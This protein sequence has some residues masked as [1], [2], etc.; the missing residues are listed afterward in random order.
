MSQSHPVLSVRNLSK[1]FKSKNP[2]LAVDD[3][4]F[5]LMQ[6]EILGLLGP[7]GA[8]KTT[9][10]QMLLSTLKP[11]SGSIVYFG[12]DFK[13][14]RSEILN[15]VVFA[16][17]Y[18]SLPYTLTVEQNLNVFGKLYGIGSKE[19][20]TRR[21]E[22]LERFGILSK[23]KMPVSTLSAGQTTRLVLVKAF[24]TKP[25]IALLDEPTASLDPDI[26]KDIISFVLE[27]RDKEGISILFTSHNMS[28]VAEV[29]DRVLFLQNGRII[30]NDEPRNLAKSASKSRI[31]L[32]LDESAD[33]VISVAKSLSIIFSHEHKR[34]TFEIDEQ[35]IAPFLLE[36][37]K[38][39]IIYSGIKI[40]E[41]TLEDY[42]LKMVNENK[43]S[44]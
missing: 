34:F 39:H 20:Q 3:I 38:H 25:K 11:T 10:I 17:T 22:L 23:L 37:A 35:Q 18:I 26:S 9:T 16:S 12:K 2:F 7:N 6:G 29:S 21:N 43:K 32:I 40:F 44:V 36:L 19:L 28:E 27:Q 33:K 30:A 41:P 13:K 5:D 1:V 14:Y 42:F 4:S 24:M 31:E 8:G 15:D